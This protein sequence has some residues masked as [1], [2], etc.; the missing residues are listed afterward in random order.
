MDTVTDSRSYV[1]IL[2]LRGQ[3]CGRDGNKP[4]MPSSSS[5]LLSS[6]ELSDAEVYEPSIRALLGTASPFCE[7]VVLKSRTVPWWLCG[8][9]LHRLDLRGGSGDSAAEGDRVWGFGR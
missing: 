7:A 8:Q 9:A 2:L 6:L 1:A 3:L 5:V 4:K